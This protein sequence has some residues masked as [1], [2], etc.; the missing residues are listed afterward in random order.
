MDE[1]EKKARV[2]RKHEILVT[3]FAEGVERSVW[4]CKFMKLSG[5][6][7]RKHIGMGRGQE[8]RL[9]VWRVRC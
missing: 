3:D 8:G 4:F 6:G 7:T 2:M 1:K 5:A 9:T